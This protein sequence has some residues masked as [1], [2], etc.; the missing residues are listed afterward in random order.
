[1][2][3]PLANPDPHRN[4]INGSHAGC[5]TPADGAL[6]HAPRLDETMN[7]LAENGTGHLT[8]GGKAGLD[9]GTD[10]QQELETLRSENDQLRALCV[11]L[12]EALQE[13]TQQQGGASWDER[14]KEYEALLEEKSDM[15]RQLHQ[16]LQEARTALA[17]AESR[18]EQA[19]PPPVVQRPA[20]TPIPR[21]EEL[22]ALSE[23]LERERRQLQEDEQ[24]LMEQM[25]HMEVSM[26][27]E[28]AEMARQR[29]DLQRLQG[30]IRH[31]LERLEKSG[32][33]QSKIENLKLKLQDFTHRRGA[34]P[35]S[36]AGTPAASPAGPQ[37][38]SAPAAPPKREGFLGR[39]FGQGGSR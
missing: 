32:A 3:N 25:R 2:G 14:V 7:H 26:A 9:A 22:L 21:E 4:G 18:A 23:E 34:A 30:E 12:E 10:L 5:L 20:N 24:T 29:N 11:E 17:E 15:I 19:P 16:Q 8:P 36:T 28:R 27:R 33:L 38:P 6:L 37:A 39:L 35:L 1:M 31:E 13:A